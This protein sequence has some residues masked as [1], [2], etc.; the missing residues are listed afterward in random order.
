[1]SSLHIIARSLPQGD[2][3][4]LGVVL[5]NPLKLGPGAKIGLSSISYSLPTA[6]I[7][8]SGDD[9]LGFQNGIAANNAGK[10]LVSGLKPGLYQN[11]AQMVPVVRDAVNSCQ[12][13]YLTGQIGSAGNDVSLLSTRCFMYA[14]N[15]AYSEIEVE[16]VGGTY[17]ITRNAKIAQTPLAT[18][19][20]A[21][22]SANVTIPGAA[23]TVVISDD[24]PFSFT[25][26]DRSCLGSFAFTAALD[27]SKTTSFNVD[28][29][30]STGNQ[31]VGME[32]VNDAGAGLQW[33]VTATVAGV[34]VNTYTV[35]FDVVNED[36][37]YVALYRV[38][39]YWAIAYSNIENTDA[40]SQLPLE[41]L[42]K[43]SGDQAEL[44]RDNWYDS[45]VVVSGLM[46]APG[47]GNI[48]RVGCPMSLI[49]PRLAPPSETKSAEVARQAARAHSNRLRRDARRAA[50][51]AEIALELA[52]AAAAAEEEYEDGYVDVSKIP[53]PRPRAQALPVRQTL[54]P[55]GS[56]LV[57]RSVS[58][59]PTAS[60]AAQSDGQ[61]D[62][63]LGATTCLSAKFAPGSI[64]PLIGFKFPDLSAAI[65]PRV[66]NYQFAANTPATTVASDSTITSNATSSS[67]IVL[68]DSIPL[69]GA[70]ADIN[71]YG[72]DSSVLD[73]LTGVQVD[74]FGTMTLYNP[75]PHYVSMRNKNELT[76]NNLQFTL[77]NGDGV[78]RAEVMPGAVMCIS[79]VGATL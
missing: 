53:E 49:A 6:A 73:F 26:K 21:N 25:V 15:T 75:T 70:I 44:L 72:Q 61:S 48:V 27:I 77:M 65:D 9:R 3:D 68:S 40:N 59:D 69:S 35:I 2:N 42:L 67:L 20:L 38:G 17:T 54:D 71:G 60:A 55:V 36:N 58:A 78:N 45:K 10:L 29:V 28:I 62:G 46:S 57:A 47:G 30:D 14:A 64:A 16:E 4:K 51:A 50:I 7:E 56:H 5:R 19:N 18:V 37:Y 79:I 63:L 41:H 22:P 8:V 13:A 23:G 76:I 24:N 39:T 31:L 32:W 66:Q 34:A 43:F 52:R 74:G 11:N 1:M 12:V 33:I